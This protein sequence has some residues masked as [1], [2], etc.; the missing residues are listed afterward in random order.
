MTAIPAFDT[1][2]FVKRLIAAGVRPEQAEAQAELQVQV[3]SGL[4]T[5]KL[6]TKE[7]VTHL[8]ANLRHDMVTMESNL[9]KDMSAMETGIRK[10]MSTSETNLR[11]EISELKVIT[12]Q[13]VGKF[14]LLSW[15]TGFLL[16]AV[17]AILF[18]LF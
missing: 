7:D 13:L 15:M 11:H 4:V 14:N 8:E 1:L 18:K 10:D 6:A 12:Q 3:L 17:M 9:R 5:D 2:A 16:T